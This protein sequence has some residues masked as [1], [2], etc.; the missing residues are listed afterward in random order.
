MKTKLLCVFVIIFLVSC[1]IQAD[2][3]YNNIE[4]RYPDD[5]STVKI[6][7]NEICFKWDSGNEVEGVSEVNEKIISKVENPLPRIKTHTKN[8]Y[9]FYTE[10]SNIKF[11]TVVFDAQS[12]NSFF[13]AYGI[14]FY[15]NDRKINNPFLY[16]VTIDTASDF[17][18]EKIGEEEISFLPIRWGFN[19]HPWAVSKYSSPKS[20]TFTCSLPS[21]IERF[22]NTV[23]DIEYLIIS[24]GFV[25]P[26]QDNLYQKNARAKTIKISYDK[27]EKTY[28]LADTADY[29]KLKLPKKI[30]LYNDTLVRLEILDVYDGTD[31]DDIVISSLCFPVIDTGGK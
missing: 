17:V 4:F 31:Y 12:K 28:T 23:N 8:Y 29:Q 30:N 5:R 1:S 24:N 10:L 9:I 3:G 16:G 20:I 22:S 13:S 25:F 2:E 7:E 6:L 15:Y 21:Y 18:Q 19:Y 26:K 14:N 11:L 27:Y